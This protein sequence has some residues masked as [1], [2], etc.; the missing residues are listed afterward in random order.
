MLRILHPGAAR[1]S[2]QTMTLTAGIART[3]LTPFWGVELTGWG[4]YIERTWKQIRDRLNATALVVDDG[5]RAVCI[6]AVDLMLVGSE[7]THDVRQ[8]IVRETGIAAE[9]I[10]VT[11]SH[12]HNAPASGGLLGV[13]EVDAT[14]E[15]WASRQAA[16]AGILAWQRR[17]A[18]RLSAGHAELPG[19]SYNRTR[20]HGSVDTRLT[21]LRVDHASGGAAGRRRQFSGSS[22]RAHDLAAVRRHARCSRRGLRSAGAGAARRHGDVP[23]G[24]MW[25]R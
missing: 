16:T 8:R 10:L 11:A 23:A 6:V 14:Y 25:R 17:V 7:F 5:N 19:L 20:D 12:S 2:I 3:D 15:S 22:N 4:Y 18:A 21:T 9:A 24:R 13:G 1:A